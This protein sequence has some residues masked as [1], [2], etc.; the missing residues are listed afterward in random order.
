MFLRY[1]YLWHGGITILQNN[2]TSCKSLQSSHVMSSYTIQQ[3]DRRSFKFTDV[4]YFF[5]A[6]PEQWQMWDLT[7]ALV[8]LDA[9]RA[10]QAI[11]SRNSYSYFY[12]SINMKDHLELYNFLNSAYSK[13]NRN[14]RS[15]GKSERLYKCRSIAAGGS[16]Q[17]V[18]WCQSVK[19][20]PLQV[21]T[22]CIKNLLY[23]QLKYTSYIKI[24]Q[25]I[26]PLRD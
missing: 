24:N 21:S 26:C 11:Q 9:S 2:K 14:S 15:G 18:T 19:N 6:Q 4:H 8:S 13:L 20:T 23:Y 1:G 10:C 25:K 17:I 3:C 12:C 22:H 7:P 16:T 5:T